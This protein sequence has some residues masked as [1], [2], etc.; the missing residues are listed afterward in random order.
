MSR[1]LPAVVL[2]ALV[3]FPACD[4]K[5]D[6]SAAPGS[7]AQAPGAPGASGDR[8]EREHEHEGDAGPHG[9]RPR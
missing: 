5:E 2:G 9:E 6:S 7:S 1:L 4:K 8:R 3:F